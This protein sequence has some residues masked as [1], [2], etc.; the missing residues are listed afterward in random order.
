MPKGVSSLVYTTDGTDPR[1]SNNAKK[2]TGD[3]NLAEML[4]ARS[5]IKISLRAVDND[6]N[7][8][9]LVNVELISKERKYEIQENLIG[10]AT[11]KCPN[12]VDSL[13]AVIKSIINY[14]VKKNIL[15]KDTAGQ[16]ATL[17]NNINKDK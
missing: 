16:V 7:Y 8:S 17:L 1:T 12:D 6:G 4:K 13:L 10:E 11:F 3:T 14:G 15:D 5:N 9:D 2:I